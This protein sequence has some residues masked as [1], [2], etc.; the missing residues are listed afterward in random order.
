[1]TGIETEIRPAVIEISGIPLVTD[2]FSWSMLTGSRSSRV[3]F[4]THVGVSNELARLKNPVSLYMDMPIALSDKTIEDNRVT[5]DLLYLLEIKA[6]PNPFLRTWILGDRR[7][8]WETLRLQRFY[9]VHWG[10]YETRQLQPGAGKKFAD[11]TIIAGIRYAQW[12]LMNKPSGRHPKMLVPTNDAS[13]TGLP[14]TALNIVYDILLNVLKLPEDHVVVDG[15]LEDNNHQPENL[16]WD[17]EDLCG[18]LQTAL[19]MAEANIY[20]HPDGKIH[21][22]S[23]RD[24]TPLNRIVKQLGQV[25]G[26]QYPIRQNLKRVR[27]GRAI[28]FFDREHE[29]RFNYLETATESL[30]SVSG[31]PLFD[32]ENVCQVSDTF[33]VNGKKYIRGSWIRIDDYLGALNQDTAN[34]N[35]LGR[36]LSIKALKEYW[37]G[38]NRLEFFYA[39]DFALPNRV[40]LLWA[41]RIASIRQSFHQTFRVS[42]YWQKRIRVFRADRVAILDTVTGT[43][44]PAGVYQDYCEVPTFRAPVRSRDR[45]RFKSARNHTNYASSLENKEPTPAVVRMLDSRLGVFRIDFLPDPSFMT[46]DMVPGNVDNIPAL[47]VGSP[48]GSVLWNNAKLRGTFNLAVIMSCIFAIPNDFDGKHAEVMEIPNGDKSVTAHMFVRGDNAR[49]GYKDG[50]SAKND[51]GKIVINGAEFVNE[52]VIKSLA[53][54][55]AERLKTSWED[56]YIGVFAQ[57]GYKDHWLPFAY[58]SSVQ[59]EYSESTGLQTVFDMS[60]PPQTLDYFNLLPQATK[61]IINR[62]IPERLGT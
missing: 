35:P 57:P 28:C 46:L 50:M 27:P 33:T 49:F 34:P 26:S 24:E 15:N 44:A 19:N 7:Y 29:I 40:D 30:S 42:P 59:V 14:W 60:E 45:S 54:A 1:M 8:K 55:E 5:F 47:S 13:G 12:S 11:F 17:G 16:I 21:I 6:A 41:Q 3:P 56:R 10:A 23:I 52:G 4:T 53:K 18:A 36:K 2:R 25:E 62:N 22:F 37:L 58:T 9:N 48:S 38:Q 20:Q 31:V 39:S 61:N 32:L 43:R 51:N